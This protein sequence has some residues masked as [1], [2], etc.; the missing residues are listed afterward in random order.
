MNIKKLY[1][2]HSSEKM[3][4]SQERFDKEPMVEEEARDFTVAH[5]LPHVDNRDR[6]QTMG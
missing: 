5:L 2:K 1:A 4:N 3:E 6:G